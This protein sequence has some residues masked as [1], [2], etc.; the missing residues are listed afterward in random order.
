MVRIIDRSFSI[1]E[2]EDQTITKVE[3]A[4]VQLRS[5]TGDFDFV[6][7]YSREEPFTRVSAIKAIPPVPW[8]PK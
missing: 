3:E 8:R 1:F 7:L 5:A 4:Y 6:L 2:N